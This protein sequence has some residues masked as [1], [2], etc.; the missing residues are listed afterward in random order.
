MTEAYWSNKHLVFEQS[1]KTL[2][3]G[4]QELDAKGI[5][6]HHDHLT[7]DQ[8]V[9]SGAPL[10]WPKP[11]APLCSLSRLDNHDRLCKVACSLSR[12]A[13]AMIELLPSLS[14]PKLLHQLH[15]VPLINYNFILMIILWYFKQ[16]KKINVYIDC[17]R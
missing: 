16:T 10:T 11:Q 1:C 2:S 12:G 14:L 4:F 6:H 3:S 13:C 7:D 9:Q 15:R 5:N 17:T 8:M